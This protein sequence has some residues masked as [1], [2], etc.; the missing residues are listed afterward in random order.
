MVTWDNHSSE[1]RNTSRV[2]AWI[3]KE[4]KLG[5]I[6][7]LG[8]CPYL[9]QPPVS[10]IPLLTVPK[11][12]D[13]LAVRVC[14]DCSY[15]QGFSHNDG[16][17]VDS[18]CGE[19]YRC[20]LP[21]I[22]DFLATVRNIGLKD[23]MLAKADQSRG[24]RQIPID[25][26]DWPLQL[27]NISPYGYFLDSRGI[28][29][30]RP[31][32][33]FMQRSNQALGWTIVNTKVDVTCSEPGNTK[34]TIRSISTYIDDSLIAAHRS[35]MTSVWKNVLGVHKA[36]NVDLSSTDGHL[37]EPA[38]TV[39]ALGFL[40]DCDEGTLSVPQP[41]LDELLIL[42]NS[43]LLTG[44]AS[45]H[46]LKVLVG[47][48]A[49]LIMVVRA[50]RR[51]I[52]RVLMLLQGPPKP[53]HEIVI[54]SEGAKQDI[55]WWTTHG[56]RLNCRALI[57][58]PVAPREAI[59]VVDARGKTNSGVPSVG[60]LFYADKE[61]F[62][63]EVTEEYYNVPVHV[64]EALALLIEARLWVNWLPTPSLVPVGSDN[65][66][67]VSA[68]QSGR[69]KDKMLAA[70]ARLLWGVFGVHGS[71]CHLRYVPTKAIVWVYVV[72]EHLRLIISGLGLG[73][74]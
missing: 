24:Y 17:P 71:I 48:L 33:S 32:G 21:T 14:G 38:R 27:Y 57:N 68:V 35:I 29:G 5:A 2:V 30:S 69:A 46:H 11:P 52:N 49:R 19:D 64:V 8:K 1:V 67:V 58:L 62:S 34:S 59:F 44:Q 3:N 47:R 74:F 4:V 43:L 36:A 50:G 72:L 20:R 31:C 23:V 40:V 28:F 39:V 53:G 10:T 70:L 66:A 61:F 15:P 60:G 9:I 42:A 22:W 55:S 51:F 54:L 73:A 16:I 63:V 56:T 26:Y 65:M 13:P 12:P 37:S 6:F 18:Y 25:P 41:K 7:C 45:V